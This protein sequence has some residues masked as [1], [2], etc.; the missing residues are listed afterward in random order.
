M[1]VD[2]ASIVCTLN[3]ASLLPERLREVRAVRPLPVNEVILLLVK[4]KEDMRGFPLILR[5]VRAGR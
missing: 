4:A 3:A 5:V 2:P 1:A